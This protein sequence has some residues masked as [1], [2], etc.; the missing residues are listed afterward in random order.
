MQAILNWFNQ[1]FTSNMNAFRWF[2]FIGLLV[3]IVA[4]WGIIMKH[5]EA[6]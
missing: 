1:P 2:L 5:L 3:V 4:L 6:V